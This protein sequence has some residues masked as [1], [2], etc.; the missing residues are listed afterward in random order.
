MT[1]IPFVVPIMP[2]KRRRVARERPI[3]RGSPPLSAACP[4]A[5]SGR[6]FVARPDVIPNFAGFR[7]EPDG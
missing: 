2:V 7:C 3:E 6:S 5:H 1:D 4:T